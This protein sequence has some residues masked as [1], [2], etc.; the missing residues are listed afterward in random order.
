[1]SYSRVTQTKYLVEDLK[2]CSAHKMWDVGNYYHIK[3]GKRGATVYYGA[4]SDRAA[5]NTAGLAVVRDGPKPRLF[6]TVQ[7]ALDW[8]VDTKI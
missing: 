3:E 7:D 8:L 4:W 1:M 6:P 2:M 5:C